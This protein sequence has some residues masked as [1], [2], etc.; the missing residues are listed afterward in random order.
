MAWGMVAGVGPSTGRL[1]SARVLLCLGAPSGVH[2]VEVHVVLHLALSLAIPHQGSA[3]W[4]VVGGG[5][6]AWAGAAAAELAL[7]SGMGGRTVGVR[8][9][10]VGVG[11]ADGQH[12]RALAKLAV[13][14][15]VGGGVDLWTGL[16]RRG[17]VA[18]H[19]EAL[20]KALRMAAIAVRGEG[21]TVRLG[22]R[23]QD[24]PVVGT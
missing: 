14:G 5:G 16:S 18:G 7:G 6:A 21:A 8:R 2:G 15:P 4:G 19:V 13:A 20:G 9:T 23:L 3:T 12:R 1:P 17:I 11:V 10:V 22:G 24:D